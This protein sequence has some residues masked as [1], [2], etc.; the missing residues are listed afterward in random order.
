MIKLAIT[1]G[2]GAGKTI[3]AELFQ[4]F[5]V[6]IFCADIRAK[7]IMHNNEQVI[8]AIKQIIGN[9]IYSDGKLDKSLMA[10]IIFNNPTKLAQVNA[11]VHPVVKQSYIDWV[12]KNTRRQ[13]KISLLES[14]LLFQSDIKQE[15]DKIIT[16]YA[17]LQ[18]RVARVCMRNKIS[19]QQ[20]LDRIK[21][22]M[23]C[24]DMM[25]LSDFVI[26]NDNK[27]LIIP[28]VIN[29]MNALGL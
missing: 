16:V 19:E 22:Q 23:N 6:P 7:E 15:V 8:A 21:N 5:D 11:V 25:K 26:Y 24:E 27:N 12:G 20:V 28:Q 18:L 2:I 17:P 14:A 9:T 3:V 4:L 1:G 10:Q 13:K 29:I